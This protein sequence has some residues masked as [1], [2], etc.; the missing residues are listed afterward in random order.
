MKDKKRGK[1]RKAIFA[2]AYAIVDD[3]IKYVLLRRKKHWKGWEFPKGKIEKFERKRKAVKREISEETGLKILRVKKMGIHG[4]YKYDKV[5]N[6][7]PGVRGQTFSLYS[8][9]VRY[10]PKIKIDNLE[11]YSGK[12][13]SFKEAYK[14]LTWP[15]QRHCLKIVNN[16]LKKRY[17]VNRKK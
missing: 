6:D 4:D 7:R 14:L 10:S 15:N 11:H 2:V 16:R 1:Y 5:L 13:A 3:E 8:A 17:S 12:W 9:K